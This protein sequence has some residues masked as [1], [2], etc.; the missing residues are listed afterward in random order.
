MQWRPWGSSRDM[1]MTDI[2]RR[3]KQWVVEIRLV[4]GHTDAMEERDLDLHVET[5]FLTT[6]IIVRQD[7]R[8][9]CARLT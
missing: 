9:Q 4:R 5:W 3:C 7:I 2:L 6:V 8:T 1:I